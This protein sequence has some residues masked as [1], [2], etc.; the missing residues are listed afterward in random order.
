MLPD[1]MYYLYWRYWKVRAVINDIKKSNI[2]FYS[3]SDVKKPQLDL[4]LPSTQET[5]LV[6]VIFFIYGGSWSSGSK[7]MYTLVADTLRKQGY[8]V[9]VP[10]Y[11]KYPEVKIEQ[12]YEDVAQALVWTHKNV[13]KYGGNPSRISVMGHSA[14]AHLGVQIILND[15]LRKM[16]SQTPMADTIALPP[17]HNLI[18]LSGVYDIDQHFLWE[19]YRG[20]EEVSGMGRVMGLTKTRF[21]SNSPTFILKSISSWNDHKKR[22]FMDQLPATLIIHGELD[23]T[24]PDS[25]AKNFHQALSEILYDTERNPSYKFLLYPDM[26]HADPVFAL[27]PFS[28]NCPKFH[29]TFL[30]EIVT[31]SRRNAD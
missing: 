31:F 3:P 30:N 1:A 4:Y 26:N 12:I 5:E 13:K 29:K 28:W 20:V 17:I 11:R 18:L 10:D 16:S 21:D 9:V 24:V 22:Q 19:S 14:G 27:M 23:H 15:I 25:S 8:L 6:P 7:L 2:P